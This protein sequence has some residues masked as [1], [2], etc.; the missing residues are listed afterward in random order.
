MRRRAT[1]PPPEGLGSLDI[2]PM[3][4]LASLDNR[5]AGRSGR[6]LLL[7][8]GSRGANISRSG[9]LSRD[10]RNGLAWEMKVASRRPP[11]RLKS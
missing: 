7:P 1:L 4:G 2:L 9:V 5:P 10:A 8:G 11:G 6:K 3:E